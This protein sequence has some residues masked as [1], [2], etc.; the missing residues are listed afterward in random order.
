[1]SDSHII[2]KETLRFKTGIFADVKG[3]LVLT[4][5]YISFTSKGSK[6]T[7]KEPEELVRVELSDVLNA[8]AKKPFASGDDMLELLCNIDGQE[9]KLKFTSFS[10]M[11]WANDVQSLGKGRGAMGGRIETNSLAGWE[12]AI[13]EARASLRKGK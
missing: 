12:Q 9:K 5:E 11:R 1:M 4:N 2:K 10:M 6:L 3:D 13:N 8:K 7:K